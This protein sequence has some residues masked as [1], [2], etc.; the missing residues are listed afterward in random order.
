MTIGLFVA[1]VAQATV[2]TWTDTVD[3]NWSN[4]A[5]W[6]ASAIPVDSLAGG[7]NGSGLSMHYTDEIVFDATNLPTM[8]FPGIGGYVGGDRDSPTMRFNSGG[9]ATFH[10]TNETAQYRGFWTNTQT[11]R[12]VL[13]V[14]DG[15]GGGAEDV[16][17]TIT[18]MAES[19]AR[20]GDNITNDFL[21]NSDGSLTFDS[22]VKFSFASNRVGRM[23]IAGGDVTINGIVSYLGNYADSLVEF[24]APGG[25]FTV[26]KGGDCP[27]ANYVQTRVGIDFLNN[28]GE[29]SSLSVVDNG[30]GTLTVTDGLRWTGAAGDGDWSNSVNW[31]GGRIPQDTLL[32]GS[33]ANPSY[34]AGL[35]LSYAN[36][37]EF[38]GTNM[39]S[40]NIPGI[41]GTVGHDTPTMN[42]NR[43][44]T[45]DL[46]LAGREKD[47]WSNSGTRTV[48]TVGDGI[49]E[50]VEDVVV[51]LTMNDDLSRHADG[52]NTFVVNSD[53][54][55]N[56]TPLASRLKF[57]ATTNRTSSFAIDG[58][59]VVVS[60]PVFN[61]TGV[62]FEACVVEFTAEGGTFTAQYGDDFADIAAVSSSLGDDFVN[63]TGSAAAYLKAKDNGAT[64]TVTV[65]KDRGMMFM[66]R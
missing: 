52:H 1:G 25:S 24:T 63:S 19:L 43:G 42:F 9:A 14:G 5:N 49:G 55:F 66:V 23:T 53:G 60:N 3:G 28:T 36:I 17:L 37:V 35:S 31:V 30:D 54:T 18:G 4:T 51:N 48:W 15:V 40:M 11:N 56:I 65:T 57:A 27:N 38:A 33:T 64:F 26:K 34:D 59:T 61:L 7:G 41:G 46:E 39:P 45:I 58:G 6:A 10:F 16:D 50:G 22:S 32:D 62:G 47:F 21:V 12:T 29:G 44:G 13:T 2:Y 20:H 8:N